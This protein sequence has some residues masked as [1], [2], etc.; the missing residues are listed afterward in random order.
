MTNDEA[1]RVEGRESRVESQKGARCVVS[2][3]LSPLDPQLSPLSRLRR[4]FVLRIL[5]V[6]ILASLASPLAAENWPQFR[7]P[8]GQGHSQAKNLPT[9]WSDTEN[10]RWKADVPGGGWSSPI[11]WERQIV[12]TTAI[13]RG[14][15]DD[16]D[17]T[18]ATLC[19]D[20]ATGKTLWQTKVFEQ[21]AADT[22]PIHAKNSHASPTPI[23]DGK[24]VW[25]HFGT[26]G[27]ACLTLDGEVVWRTRELEY[28]PRH[29]SGGSPVLVGDLL[30]VSCDG[31]DVQFVAA[32]DRKTGE[33]RWKRDRPPLDRVQKFSFST[34][35]VIEVGG[36]QQ[37]VSPGTNRVVAYEPASGRELWQVDYDGYS[38]IPRPVYAHGLVYVS[39]SYN[40][41]SLLAIRPEGGRNRDAGIAWQ[42][43]RYAP[44]TP[45]V[46]AVGDELY[47]VSDRGIASCVDARTG[48]VH[49][50]E[51]LGGNYSASPIYGDGKVYFQSEQGV[52]TVIRAGKR[53]EKLAENDI[54]ARTLASYAVV[55]S[56][57]LIRTETALYR[58][59][60]D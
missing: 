44:H 27:T 60:A 10:V 41:A 2:C 43:P 38:V 21:S 6:V 13:P 20:A 39:T 34:P 32:L 31:H 9:R 18:L 35:L 46:L 4:T 56:D 7:G 15:G 57:L 5:S 36:Q 59:H 1:G 24:H 58:I 33:I 29:G 51:R 48:E 40:D 22:L 52:G 17:A 11:V 37:L 3:R 49:W 45:S 30:V 42:T 25:V 50:Q 14:T 19:L 8:T 47:F 26:E 16:R 55:D 28:D 23:T 12:L 53:Y 54:A